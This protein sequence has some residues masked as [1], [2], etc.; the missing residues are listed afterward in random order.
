M[1]VWSGFLELLF[2][3][4]NTFK[5]YLNVVEP[6]ESQPHWYRVTEPT[7]IDGRDHVPDHHGQGLG[8]KLLG[9]GDILIYPKHW[10]IYDTVSFVS[11]A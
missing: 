6:R 7:G 5:L 4:V 3:T 9:Q 10:R 1:D 2:A 11:F 8:P